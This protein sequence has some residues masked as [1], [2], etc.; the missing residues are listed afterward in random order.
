MSEYK[1]VLEENLPKLI[2]LYN[3]DKLS[4]SHGFG[5]RLYWGWKVRDFC[6]AT[7]QGGVHALAIALQM[8]LIR[9]EGFVLNLIDKAILA[10][11]NI[12][13]SSDSVVEAYP[14]E[15]SFCVTA[16]VA[17]DVLSAIDILDDRIK[18]N[19]KGQY[20][21]VVE[22]LIGF[23]ERND[24]E[25]AI[26]SNHLATA[27]AAIA[28]WNKFSSKRSERH[29]AL[30]DIIYKHQSDEGWYKEYE[31]ADPGYQTLCT[32]YLAVAN[33]YLKNEA[34]AAS[35]ERSLEYLKYFVQ[36]D[37]SIGGLYGSRNTEVFYPGGLAILAKESTLA[38][39]IL[40]ELGLGIK[41]GVHV[42]PLIIDI[43]NYAPLLNSYA[44][45]A[46]VLKDTSGFS[47]STTLPFKTQFS[48]NFE[49]SGI[50]I[51]STE[52]YYAILN[53]KKG[54]T[55]KVFN[56]E[57]GILDLEDGGWVAKNGKGK[58]VSTQQ[59]EQSRNFEGGEFNASFFESNEA[60][61]SPFQF[62]VLRFLSITIFKSNRLGNMFKRAIVKLLMTGKKKVDGNVRRK[63]DFLNSKIEIREYIKRPKNYPNVE[64]GA[65]FKSI[66]MASSG[67]N[68]SQLR[69]A[70]LN[71][72]FVAFH[73]EYE[74]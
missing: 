13:D 22:P 20:L 48:K 61:P 44:Y 53:Y 64:H 16:L 19:K 59:I 46:W 2:N 71:S 41:G 15:Q 1:S 72:K 23:L 36:P 69:N 39:S 54:G 8:G 4:E 5:D 26:I 33:H 63:F 3:L 51:H 38:R 67:Y 62:M 7:L 17:F 74:D 68:T 73:I 49:D 47:N 35:L 27:V 12:K 10:I 58:W 24:E 42:T 25:H 11:D 65:K 28:I 9:E 14:N 32:Y 29:K 40:S 30:L 43:G 66:H 18:A 55:L 31:G 56:K 52:T 37:G 70:E 60:Y 34:L 45:A 6:N 57:K 50:Y 21:A